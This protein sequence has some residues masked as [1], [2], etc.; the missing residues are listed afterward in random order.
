VQSTW[1]H[2]IW[3]LEQEKDNNYGQMVVIIMAVGII[4]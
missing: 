4:I 1:V 3:A 2:G